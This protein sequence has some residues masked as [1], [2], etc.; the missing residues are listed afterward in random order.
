LKPGLSTKSIEVEDWDPG[1]D[2]EDNTH[3]AGSQVGGAGIFDS[4]ALE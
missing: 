1:E 4:A 3:A 2:E